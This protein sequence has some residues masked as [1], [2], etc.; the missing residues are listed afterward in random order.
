MLFLYN[1]VITLDREVAYFWSTKPTGAALLF[2]ANKWI[3]ITAGVVLLAS[4]AST[5]VRSVNNKLVLTAHMEPASRG[6]YK[7]RRFR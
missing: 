2:F 5:K 4:F 1:S 6:W 7:L 3:N